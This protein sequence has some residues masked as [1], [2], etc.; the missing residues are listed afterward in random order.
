M[1]TKDFRTLQEASRGPKW[2]VTNRIQLTGS[3]S[4]NVSCA[5]GLPVLWEGQMV[6]SKNCR[7]RANNFLL[8]SDAGLSRITPRAGG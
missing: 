8:H 6:G 1:C 3:Y 5:A 7:V 4:F 2:S